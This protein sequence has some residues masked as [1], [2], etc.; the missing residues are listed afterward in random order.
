MRSWD[1]SVFNQH[2]GDTT[3]YA[4]VIGQ[5]LAGKS[6]VSTMISE[7]T[8]SKMIDFAKIGEAIR[9]RLETE[10]GPFEGRIP[11]AEIEKDVLA[12]IKADKDA[13]CKFLYVVDG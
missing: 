8:N 12:M 10:D 7:C 4:L 13:G 3:Q 1:E 6:L 2:L 5:P 11:D 9:P